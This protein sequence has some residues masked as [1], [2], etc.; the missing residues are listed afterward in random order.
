MKA[1]FV[2]RLA[3]PGGYGDIAASSRSPIGGS[4]PAA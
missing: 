4:K 3:L 2:T 1:I